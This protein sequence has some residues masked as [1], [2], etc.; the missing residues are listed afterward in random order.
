MEDYVSVDLFAGGGG[1]SVGYEMATGRP[2]D[3]AINHDE[4]ALSMHQANHP[5]T[6]H[7]KSDIFELDPRLVMRN[8]FP[9]RQIGFLWASPDCTGFSKAKGSAPRREKDRKRRALA[10]V[11]IRWAGQVRPKV[12][13]LENVEEFTRWTRLVGRRDNYRECRKTSGKRFRRFVRLLREMGYTV[14]WRELRACAYG[15]ATIRKRL[16]LQATCDGHLPVWPEATHGDPAALGFWASGLRRW[17]VTANHIDWT[18]PM[19]SVFASK[20]EAREWGKRHGRNSP[21]RPLKPNSMGRIA[22]GVRR[23]VID[24][25]SPYFLEE[26]PDGAW[27]PAKGRGKRRRAAAWATQDRNHGNGEAPGQE[28]RCQSVDRPGA[29]IVPTGNGHVLAA[30]HL[31][32]Y[33]GDASEGRSGGLDAP[34]PTQDTSNRFGIAAAAMV[35]N[36]GGFFD[37]IGP[38]IEEPLGTIT[39]D[40]RG[41]HG[42]IAAVGREFGN[43]V[44][45]RVDGPVGTVT[46]GGQGKTSLIAAHVTRNNTGHT[47]S[48]GA[49]GPL[50]TVVADGARHSV[51]GTRLGGDLGRAPDVFAFLTQYNGTATGDALDRPIKT[52]SCLDRYG[53]VGV[54]AFRETW[55]ITDILMRML[56]A[57]ELFGC[58]GFPR[59]YII[60]RGHDGR[61]FTE[62][63]KVHFCGN[64]VSPYAACAIIRANA[65]HMRGRPAKALVAA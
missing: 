35:Q 17:D 62:T 21:Q 41:H 32:I 1:A 16:Y 53:L 6:L 12:I 48:H 20:E 19:C 26:G 59:S 10:W 45:Q 33:H 39:C 42:L 64:S 2:V 54:K 8:F 63:Q 15:A 31:T 11:V 40:G 46:P 4:D 37:G 22:R 43:S 51:V 7:I 27:R 34:L 36:N 13:T 55:V 9:G 25:P 49:D 58:Q 5:T 3:V 61:V 38:G 30:A 23:F 50:H 29:S 18:Q 44:G 14:E 28:P 57:R 52:I 56:R 60:D 24:N 65:P 47:P